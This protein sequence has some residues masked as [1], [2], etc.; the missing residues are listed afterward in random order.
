MIPQGYRDCKESAC[1]NLIQQHLPGQEQAQLRLHPGMNFL[2]QEPIASLG[3]SALPEDVS[4]VF[5]IQVTC[6]AGLHSDTS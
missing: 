2:S 3:L 6:L 5:N 4:S 1:D